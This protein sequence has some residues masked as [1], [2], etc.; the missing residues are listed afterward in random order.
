MRRWST[1]TLGILAF[2][3]LRFKPIKKP[4]KR[5]KGRTK[6]TPSKQRH[7]QKSKRSNQRSKMECFA[8][9][10]NSFLLSNIFAKCYI[11]DVWQGSEYTSGK[12]IKISG[13]K[14]LVI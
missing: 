9:I 12:E 11:F 3:D 8:K 7:I 1:T 4:E 13:V 5:N 14:Y 6:E 10:V 2:R